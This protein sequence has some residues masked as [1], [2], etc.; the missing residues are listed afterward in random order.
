MRVRTEVSGRGTYLLERLEFKPRLAQ[1]FILGAQLFGEGLYIRS[2]AGK[3]GGTVDSLEFAELFPCL[4]TSLPC[5]R[6]RL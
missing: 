3:S 6:F 2:S 5:F 4:C 1:L